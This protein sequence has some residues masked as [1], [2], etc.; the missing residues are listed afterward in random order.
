LTEFDTGNSSFIPY[1]SNGKFLIGNGTAGVRKPKISGMVTDTNSIGLLIQGATNNTNSGA[2]MVYEIRQNSGSF[3]SD[4]TTQTGSGFQW[5]RFLTTLM[6]L[7]RD[8]K[9]GINT[10]T[11]SHK[12]HV[13]GSSKITGELDVSKITITGDS[14]ESLVVLSESASA[15]VG[16]QGRSIVGRDTNTGRMYLGNITDNSDLISPITLLKKYRCLLI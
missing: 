4:Y 14:G 8:G 12:L 5:V 15:I 1:G 2:D 6:T 13:D 9:L 7:T 11:P 10:T 3:G 16:S